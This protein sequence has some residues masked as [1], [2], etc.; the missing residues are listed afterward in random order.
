M[1]ATTSREPSE[2][3]VQVTKRFEYRVI[4]TGKRIE[5]ATRQARCRRVAGRGRDD[6]KAALDC[7]APGDHPDA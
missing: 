3:S 6:E 2:S 4:D 7:A 1:M 5:A